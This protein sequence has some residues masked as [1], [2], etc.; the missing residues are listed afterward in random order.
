MDE[1]PIEIERLTDASV[2]SATIATLQF[3]YWRALTGHD[4]ALGYE[5][6]LKNAARSARLPMVLVARRGPMYVGSANLLASEM[7]I[8]PALSPWM[9]QLFVTDSSRGRGVGSA[10]I[11]AMMNRAFA[12][13]F[14]RVHLFTSGPLP[15]YYAAQGWKP[16]EEVEYLG[17]MRTVMAIDLP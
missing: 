12:L 5:E 17:K 7:T 4:T 13:G 14:Q 9:A 10:L 11:Q 8:R 1:P 3:A 15:A 6:F 2:L 16:V